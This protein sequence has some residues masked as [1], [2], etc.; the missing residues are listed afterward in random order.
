[1]RRLAAQDSS[2]DLISMDV[3]WTAEFAGAKWIVPWPRAIAAK[4]AQGVV[5]AL[6]ATGRYKGRMYAGPL[7]A[8]TQLLWYRKDL[9]PKPPTTWSE[10]IQMTRSL[11]AGQRA[12][13]VQAAKYEGLTVWFNSLL[14]SAGGRIVTKSGKVSLARQPTQQ[15][16]QVMHD[17][18]QA[19]GADPS[20]SNNLEDDGRLAFQAGRAAFMVNYPFVD[21]AIKAGNPAVYKNMGVALWPRVDPN[22]PAHVTLGG[23]NLG[24]GA[25]SNHKSVDFQ[26]AQCL[27][28]PAQQI[29]YAKG[30]GL[31]PI[32]ESLYQDPRV[33]KAFPYADL[34]LH[35][36]Q[37]GS[38]RPVTP[39]YND[40]SLAVQDTLHP[41]GSIN[42]RSDVSTLRSRVDDA[43]NS[44]GLL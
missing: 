16:M 11:P 24:V 18:A 5:P 10:M 35:T 44:R 42:P 6:L 38:T 30:D 32:T 15:A 29:T 39:A 40:V 28:Q 23:F 13:E 9:V 41:P 43:L 20:I 26:A 19:P 7:D 21:P 22:Q 2:I 14:A 31:A 33:R 4:A 27:Q 1:V 37:E 3:V 36:L 34:L 17:V 25:F 12:I 8:A